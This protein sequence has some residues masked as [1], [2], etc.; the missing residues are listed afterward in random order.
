MMDSGSAWPS[1]AM[2]E[3]SMLSGWMCGVL[4]GGRGVPARGV[5]ALRLEGPVA[6]GRPWRKSFIGQWD[7]ELLERLQG[8]GRELVG[9][10]I[11]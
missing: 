3:R 5:S 6:S 10:R 9:E 8:Q 2:S 11:A 1:S 7:W 4:I